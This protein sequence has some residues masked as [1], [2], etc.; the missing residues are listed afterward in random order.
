[1]TYALLVLRAIIVIARNTVREMVHLAQGFGLKVK[2]GTEVEFEAVVQKV[3][4]ARHPPSI[5][6]GPIQALLRAYH[7]CNA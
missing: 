1:V 5:T 2:Q 6:K 4:E 3:I 7:C